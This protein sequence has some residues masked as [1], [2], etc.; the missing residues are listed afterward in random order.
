MWGAIGR[1]AIWVLDRA[2]SGLIGYGV[3]KGA[4]I[5]LDDDK[6]E[7]PGSPPPSQPT[8]SP[9]KKLSQL[10][11]NL[12]FAGMRLLESDPEINNVAREFGILEQR[13]DFDN[14]FNRNARELEEKLKVLLQSKIEPIAQQEAQNIGLRYQTPL[15]NLFRR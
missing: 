14:P 13:G 4:D 10:Y 8:E 5:I 15:G 7:S 6:S 3:G 12:S 11:S 1:G 2:I 9:E